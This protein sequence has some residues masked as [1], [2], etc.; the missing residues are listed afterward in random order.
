VWDNLEKPW[1]WDLLSSSK[2]ITWDIIKDNPDKPWNLISLNYNPNITWDIIKDNPDS[3]FNLIKI[4][5]AVW[6]CIVSSSALSANNIF[7]QLNWIEWDWNA[8]SSNTDIT[9]DIVKNNP[10]KPWNFRVLSMNPN[11]T[12]CIV[13]DNPDKPWDWGELSRNP[14]MLLSNQELVNIIK[15]DKS[16]QIIQKA[17]R[18]S[19]SNPT[20]KVCK[21]RLF[22]EFSE[23]QDTYFNV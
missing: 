23:F 19:I 7:K 14:S 1:N 10:D 4:L 8:L 13:Q 15:R 20:Y 18:H 17:W 5:R 22:L 9:W 6:Y 3:T 21:K 2:N 11:I 12:W 16:V